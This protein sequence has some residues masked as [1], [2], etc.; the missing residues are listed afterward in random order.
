MGGPLAGKL[1][2]KIQMNESKVE[3]VGRSAR[4]RQQERIKLEQDAMLAE[5]GE[6][7]ELIKRSDD[8]IG[9]ELPWQA[10]K[11]AREKVLKYL[12]ELGVYEKVD[13]RTAVAKYNDTSVDTK[14]VGSDKT[15]EGESQC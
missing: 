1:M 2:K 10:V 3:K 5:A 7:N 6:E 9:E 11:E 12:R 4:F 13:E 14:R 15:F 8:I